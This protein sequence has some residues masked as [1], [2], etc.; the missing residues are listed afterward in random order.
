MHS[1]FILPS[2]LFFEDKL[3]AVL[4]LS[5]P[6]IPEPK[7]WALHDAH[8]DMRHA[9]QRR[10]ALSQQAISKD[11]GHEE[12]DRWRKPPLPD[13]RWPLGENEVSDAMDTGVMPVLRVPLWTLWNGACGR[14]KLRSGC[15]WS[16]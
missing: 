10:G 5:S 6:P 16:L 15:W 4:I 7:L 14:Q 13:V 3:Y 8:T 9:C 1:V 12:A 2:P 11:A